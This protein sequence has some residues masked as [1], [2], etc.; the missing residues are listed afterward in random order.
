MELLIFPILVVISNFRRK[1]FSKVLIPL[2]K[3]LTKLMFFRKFR[4]YLWSFTLLFSTCL[5]NLVYAKTSLEVYGGYQTSPHSVLSGQYQSRNIEGELL[6]FAVTAGWKGKSFSMPPYYGVRFTKWTSNS[7]WGLD[8]THSKAYADQATLAKAGF[9]LLQFTDGLNNVTLHRQFMGS[10][11]NNKYQ[12][13]YGYG[14]GIIVPHVEFQPSDSLQRTFEYQYGG[15][16]IA[17][18]SGFKLPI[19]RNRFVFAEYKF[20]ASWLDVDLRGGGDL[21]TRIFTNALNIGFGLDF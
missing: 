13:Y 3:H 21:Q 4:F 8:F 11:L 6:P 18:N 7:G 14:V 20:T 17:F 16:T 5:T 1:K 15:P 10:T 2:I 12:S 9:R 19:K